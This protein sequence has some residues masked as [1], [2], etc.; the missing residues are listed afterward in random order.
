MV[1]PTLAGH[2]SRLLRRS[3]H[4]ELQDQALAA[5]VA[6][7]DAELSP[8]LD[9]APDV[10]AEVPVTDTRQLGAC[11]QCSHWWGG[12]PGNNIHRKTRQGECRIRVEPDGSLVRP[13]QPQTH[14]GVQCFE[15]FPLPRPAH[16]PRSCGE[17]RFWRFAAFKPG[18]TDDPH[19]DMG[20]CL[21]RAPRQNG[22]RDG[23]EF[24][25]TSRDFFCGDGIAL[26]PAELAAAPP[27]PSP[28]PPRWAQID[29]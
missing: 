27:R 18:A 5:V 19:N 4:P 2:V 25:N 6:P 7:D 15:H 26:T 3:E 29:R 9:A 20:I 10:V 16:L 12:P 13:H 23:Y 24:L 21:A 1:T 22:K 28:P 17:C 8:V 11:A 14:G